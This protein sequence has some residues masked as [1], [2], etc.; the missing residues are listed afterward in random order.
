MNAHISIE[1]FGPKFSP[2]EVKFAASLITVARFTDVLLA[3]K[4]LV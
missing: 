1:Q 4:V 3:A 2:R